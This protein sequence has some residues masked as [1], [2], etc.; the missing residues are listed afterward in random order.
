MS[1][2]SLEVVWSYILLPVLVLIAFVCMQLVLKTSWDAISTREALLKL[3]TDLLIL[4]LTLQLF[5]QV[6][7][8]TWRW[9]GLAITCYGFAMA[10]FAILQFF[11][12]PGLLYGFIEPR[13]G[14]GVFGPYVNYNHYA[15]LMEMLIPMAGAFVVSLEANHW[16]KP[17]LCFSVLICVGS[18][19]LSGSRGGLLA[20]G[21]ESA[22]FAVAAFRM[23]GFSYSRTNRVVITAGA[24]LAALALF[25]WI[26]PV[27]IWKR[28]EDTVRQPE[29]ALENRDKMS[30]DA[31]RMSRHHLAAGVGLGAFEVAYPKNQTVVTDL[32]IDHAH[33]DYAEMFAESGLVGW[34]LVPVSIAVFIFLSF[35]KVRCLLREEAS[36]LRLGAVVGI[37]GI[38][39]H[40]F[41]DFNLHIPANA[42]WF[43]VLA[44]IA[45][46]FRTR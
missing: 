15:G 9:L 28:W 30:L 18:V 14:G 6:S 2:Q 41:S 21:V 36:W 10:L 40:S 17:L 42:A 35:S 45:V 26:D 25:A 29:V 12:N 46:Q 8:R 39:V 3:T 22:A 23:A 16:A 34:L 32:V 31:L 27:H 5:S 43:S 33:N 4:F 38:L 13:W 1:A 37:Y 44:G 7:A 19:F 20:L 11:A 24:L